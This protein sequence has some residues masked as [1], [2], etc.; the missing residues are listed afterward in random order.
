MKKLTT[1]MKKRIFDMSFM[2]I[3]AIF[4]VTLNNFDL[5]EE[6][7]GYALIPIT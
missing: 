6:Y 2:I 1:S 4:L 5:I 7:I 3:A